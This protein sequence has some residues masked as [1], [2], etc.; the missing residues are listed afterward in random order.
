MGLLGDEMNERRQRRQQIE[1]AEAESLRTLVTLI[2]EFTGM[3]RSQG[4]KPS[5]APG[6]SA[7]W[8][9]RLDREDYDN[10]G[11]SPSTDRWTEDSFVYVFG[12]S[13]SPYVGPLK[14][15]VPLRTLFKREISSDPRHERY[16]GAYKSMMLRV[17]ERGSGTA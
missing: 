5:D 2:H 17:L 15:H 10:V 14:E 1:N 13:T 3:C 11:L 12:Q 9:L 7:C 6:A 8:V 16:V 4:V